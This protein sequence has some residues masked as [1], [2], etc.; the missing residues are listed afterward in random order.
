MYI[1]KGKLLFEENIDLIN[2]EINIYL[3]QKKT[4]VL[5]KKLVD[6][7]A[8]APDNEVLHTILANLYEKTNDNDNAVLEVF[9]SIRNKTRF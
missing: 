5:K 9:K 1:E 2:Q 8:I 4:D 6:A 7:I 3:A